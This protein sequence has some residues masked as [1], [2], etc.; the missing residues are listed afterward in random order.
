M[1]ARW[2]KGQHR[3]QVASIAVRSQQTL[4][5]PQT[6]N[7]PIV[8][9]CTSNQIQIPDHHL[10]ELEVIWLPAQLSHIFSYRTPPHYPPELLA[11]FSHSLPPQ[12]LCICHY[13]CQAC[14]PSPSLPWM[15]HSH[16][17]G[18]LCFNAESIRAGTVPAM[19]TTVFSNACVSSTQKGPAFNK[20]L[21][22]E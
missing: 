9:Y 12:G 1:Q 15:I 13:P 17:S 3:A 11:P 4:F 16:Y 6:I 2:G 10:Q 19:V 7:P 22:N 8:L 14:S 5:P 21:L 18:L 20:Y